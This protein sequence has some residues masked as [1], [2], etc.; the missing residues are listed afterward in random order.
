MLFNA[1]FR[2]FRY[3]INDTFLNIP[4]LFLHLPKR[5]LRDVCTTQNNMFCRQS[6]FKAESIIHQARKMCFHLTKME[7]ICAKTF[8]LS[9]KRLFGITKTQIIIFHFNFRHALVWIT[10][11]RAAV[12]ALSPSKCVLEN[13]LLQE[14]RLEFVWQIS[15][16]YSRDD[17]IKRGEINFSLFR[18]AQITIWNWRRVKFKICANN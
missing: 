5:G 2:I 18:F 8:A 15:H 9:K 11:R 13:V 3:L 12:C 7:N 10:Q 16:S 17:D 1:V 6:L 4:H 14:R